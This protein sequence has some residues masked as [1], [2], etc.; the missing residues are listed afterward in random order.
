MA[1]LL[2]AVFLA[3]LPFCSADT[4]PSSP[5]VS[6]RKPRSLPWQQPSPPDFPSTAAPNG[7]AGDRRPPPSSIPP[8]SV[9]F[10]V[11]GN[12]YPDG[13]YYVSINI[14]DPPKPYFLDIDTGS[15]VTWLQCDAPCIRC[16]QGPHPLYRP[17]KKRLVPCEDPLCAAL[18]ESTNH[19]A[20]C[21]IPEQCDYE[22][23]Y[24]D[25]G[26]S[27]GVLLSDS[28]ALRLTNSSLAQPT[29]AFGCG[30]DQQAGPSSGPNGRSPT[31]GVLG[32]G[33]GKVSILSQLSELGICRS[34]VGHCLSRQSVGFMFFGENVVPPRSV[35]WIPMAR[36]AAHGYY[37][38]GVAGVYAGKQQLGVR[39]AVVFDS[40]SSYTYFNDQLYQ[41]LLSAVIIDISKSKTPLKE[42]PE[43]KALP[44]C[45]KG[46]RPFKSVLD[47][48]KYFRPLTLSFG[49][50]KAPALMEI[51]PENY[52]IVT[53]QGNACLGV[54]N[55][56]EVGLG[57]LNVI[58]DIS[59]QDVMVVYDNERQRIGW[60]RVAGC[61]RLPKFA[62]SPL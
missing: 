4:T 43:D 32:L 7:I 17:A 54:L 49:N 38:P 25:H 41:S 16:S 21:G 40:G 27:I 29:L 51:P 1:V 28:F 50:G 37:S 59:M 30:Y 9:V 35:T 31:D 10:P 60:A 44:H 15:D 33:S 55:G 23:Q 18:H 20:G 47:L 52:F 14:G 24:Q 61:G 19:E 56:D 58:G 36:N 34:V 48:R 62:N 2:A 3:G 5:S 8:S 53:R 12:V 45:W 39:Q 42:A 6:P 57:G 13:F 11:Y 26:S 46:S 22:I